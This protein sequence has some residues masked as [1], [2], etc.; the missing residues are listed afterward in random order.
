MRDWEGLLAP[1]RT[2]GMSVCFGASEDLQP[3]EDLKDFLNLQKS[4]C[5]LASVESPGSY[6]A[7]SLTQVTLGPPGFHVRPAR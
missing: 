4:G 7:S 2:R 3:L 6:R 5:I 1:F